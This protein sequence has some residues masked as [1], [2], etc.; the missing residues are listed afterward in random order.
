MA[1]NI[2]QGSQPVSGEPD[3]LLQGLINNH[4][5]DDNNNPDATGGKGQNSKRADNKKNPYTVLATVQERLATK[6]KTLE[7]AQK[8]MENHRARL[9][10]MEADKDKYREENLDNQR[11]KIAKKGNEIDALQKAILDMQRERAKA[12]NET[13]QNPAPTTPPK[14]KPKPKTR[15]KKKIRPDTWDPLEGDD[16]ASEKPVKLRIQKQSCRHCQVRL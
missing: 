6:A 10:K 2:P 14:I 5:N 1:G 9:S 13:V 15:E 12:L 3:D 16:S 7:K 4:N 8:V 11:K